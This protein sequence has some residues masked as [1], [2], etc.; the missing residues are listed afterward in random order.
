MSLQINLSVIEK[1]PEQV[2]EEIQ[3][4]GTQAIQ[5]LWQTSQDIAQQEIETVK[6]RYQQYKVEV[7]QQ[8]QDALDKVEQVN[9]EITNAKGVIETL[10]RENKSLQV[11]LERKIGELKS[12]QD[13]VTIVHEK[14]AQQEYEAKRLI[15]ESGRVHEKAEGLKKRLY[16]VNRQ[17]EQDRTALN[18]VREELAVTLHNRERLEKDIKTAKQETND[19]WKQFKLEQKQTA[20]AE[21]LVQEMK[22]TNKKYESEIKSLK[23]EKQEIKARLETEA[24]TRLDLEKKVAMLQGRADYHEMAHK[25]A[26]AKLEQEV[27]LV[28]S[29]ASTIRNR[30]IKAEAA[31]EREKNACERLETKLVAATGAKP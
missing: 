13:Q 21:A 17:A 24:K 3:R 19:V 6:K 11:D 14:L 26:I 2:P 25:E 29:E 9:N 28:K 8:R 27:E 7:L 12:A 16:E 30:M 5:I 20:V 4:I 18:E 23:A 10:K 31:L 15:E 22:E 1:N